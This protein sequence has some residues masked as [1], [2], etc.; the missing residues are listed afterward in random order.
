[1]HLVVGLLAQIEVVIAL[2]GHPHPVRLC[3]V[4]KNDLPGRRAD[5]RAGQKV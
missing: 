5:R 4:G 3:P 2:L 1:M